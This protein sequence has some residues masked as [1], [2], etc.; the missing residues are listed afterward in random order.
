MT[1]RLV[2]YIWKK[3]RK[4]GKKIKLESKRNKI[5]SFSSFIHV[6]KIGRELSWAK[7]VSYIKSCGFDI[8][9]NISLHNRVATLLVKKSSLSNFKLPWVFLILKK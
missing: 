6:W 3:L 2:F 5:E 8:L 1:K 4:S 9:L 7:K